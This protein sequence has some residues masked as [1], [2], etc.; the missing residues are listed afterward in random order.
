MADERR[1]DRSSA[2]DLLRSQHTFPGA[3]VFRVVV[4]PAEATAVVSAVAAALVGL[5]DVRGVHEQPSRAGRYLS[6]RIHAEVSVPE[7]VLD[8]YEVL[9]AVDGVI[10]T[11]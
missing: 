5:G 4:R 7:T 9:A 3:Y 8:V 2:L 10:M 6:L 11:L 1:L